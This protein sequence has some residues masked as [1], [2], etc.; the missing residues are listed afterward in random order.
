MRSLIILLFVSKVT[1]IT[2]VECNILYNHAVLLEVAWTAVPASVAG[3][4]AEHTA[5]AAD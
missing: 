4:A 5:P 2:Q 3:G 1:S